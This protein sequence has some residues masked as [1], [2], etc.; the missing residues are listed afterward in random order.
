MGGYEGVH[1]FDGTHGRITECKGGRGN[2]L[3]TEFV[4]SGRKGPREGKIRYF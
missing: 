3:P 2:A 4:K 1:G